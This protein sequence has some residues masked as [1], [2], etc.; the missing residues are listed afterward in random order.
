MSPAFIEIIFDIHSH[1]NL[2]TAY[3]IAIHKLIFAE[4]Y[5]VDFVF[6]LL[7]TMAFS[8]HL[9]SIVCS[10]FNRM[11]LDVPHFRQI[12]ASRTSYH[13][14]VPHYLFTQ[15]FLTE[16]R[17]VQM[18][19]ILIEREPRYVHVEQ[20]NFSCFPYKLPTSNRRTLCGIQ[21]SVKLIICPIWYKSKCNYIKSGAR[22]WGEKKSVYENFERRE[23]YKLRKRLDIVGT[24]DCSVYSWPN[25]PIAYT[26]H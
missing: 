3:N 13:S 1:M 18:T 2:Y 12:N 11:F 25:W 4:T 15:Q 6:A 20:Y 26:A 14:G 23:K 10:E 9:I 19:A 21:C 17:L 22:R 8:S 16:Q 5:L 7:V 24:Q